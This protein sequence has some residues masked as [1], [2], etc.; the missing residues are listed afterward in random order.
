[1][2]LTQVDLIT[3][4][5]EAAREG[6]EGEGEETNTSGGADSGGGGVPAAAR[7]ATQGPIETVRSA[8]ELR[9]PKERR[10]VTISMEE[11]NRIVNRMVARV[12]SLAEAYPTRAELIRFYLTGLTT[13]DVEQLQRDKHVAELV[14]NRLVEEG[15]LLEL[16]GQTEEEPV[17]LFLHP[18][19]DPDSYGG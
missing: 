8:A 10:R 3:S 11:F 17:R 19:V 4:I 13:S 5:D 9:K 7:Q 12:H 16:P 6:M 18:D 2:D 1:L 14:L 15:R